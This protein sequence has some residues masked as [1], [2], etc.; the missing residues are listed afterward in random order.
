MLRN[1]RSQLECSQVLAKRNLYVAFIKIDVVRWA[2]PGK[3]G[4]P[5]FAA[6]GERL[7]KCPKASF[8]KRRSL[9]GFL[10]EKIIVSLY[11]LYNGH[12]SAF[13]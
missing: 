8:N 2:G 9:K 11:A 13:A 1:F 10:S 5:N 4:V 6:Q 7:K 3:K 12:A